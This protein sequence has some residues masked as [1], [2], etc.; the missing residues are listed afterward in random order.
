M[1]KPDVKS[2]SVYNCIRI[3]HI[4]CFVSRIKCTVF[5]L[6]YLIWDFSQCGCYEEGNVDNIS[7]F[8]FFYSPVTWA[9]IPIWFIY[10]GV[11]ECDGKTGINLGSSLRR[12]IGVTQTPDCHGDQA[13]NRR[14]VP[15]FICGLELW[16]FMKEW[17]S[18]YKEPET[19]ILQGA[20]NKPNIKVLYMG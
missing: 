9:E 6:F 19:N 16:L 2:N 20:W 13:L 5:Q 12:R 7:L 10:W 11:W 17:D 15:G 18:S 3:F 8:F 14:F 1:N 4:S